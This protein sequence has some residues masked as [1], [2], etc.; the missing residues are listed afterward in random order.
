MANFN[1]NVKHCFGSNSALLTAFSLVQKKC[2]KLTPRILR[3]LPQKFTS[4]LSFWSKVAQACEECLICANSN[5]KQKWV[6]WECVDERAKPL[7]NTSKYNSQTLKLV[8]ANVSHSC[9]TFDQTYNFQNRF[10]TTQKNVCTLRFQVVFLG[11]ESIVLQ[12]LV[13]GKKS[14]NDFW[15]GK[16]MWK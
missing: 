8:F 11:R 7:A 10:W 12:T 16:L 1:P 4:K 9:A 6:K 5:L 3:F 14:V 2:W 13:L 15:F